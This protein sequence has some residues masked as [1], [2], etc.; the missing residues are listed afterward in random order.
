MK[1]SRWGRRAS[2]QELKL[3]IA[4]LKDFN[5]VSSFMQ[6]EKIVTM[7]SGLKGLMYINLLKRI[8]SELHSAL[9]HSYWEFITRK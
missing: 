5:T 4:L 7:K 9:C 6:F 3:A 1:F 8:N 2:Y